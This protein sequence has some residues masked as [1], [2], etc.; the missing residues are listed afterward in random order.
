[1]KQVTIVNVDIRDTSVNANTVAEALNA[2]LME[3]QNKGCIIMQGDIQ[4]MHVN[5][6]HYVYS[7]AYD[8]PSLDGE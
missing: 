2:K 5:I 1:M 8:D 6:S 7:V 4:L 3:L